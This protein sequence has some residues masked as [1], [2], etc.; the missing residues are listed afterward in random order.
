MPRIT[1]I[2][3]VR[4]LLDRDRSWAAYAIGD[5][6]PELA[7][8]CSWHAPADGSPALL[9]LYRGFDPPIVFAMGDPASLA[10]LFREIDA[11]AVSLHVRPDAIAAMRPIYRLTDIREVWR[12]V[13]PR[14]S[15]RPVSTAGV[16]ALDEFDR[17]AVTALIEDGRQHDEGPTF[18][19]PWMLRQGTFRGI[20][21]GA[22]LIAVAGTHLFSPDLGVCAVGKYTRGDRRRQGLAAC[23]TTAVVQQAISHEIATIL[24]NVGQGNA[25]ARRVY[26]RLGFHC[27]CAFVEG[28]ALRSGEV[29]MGPH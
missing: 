13:V 3:R 18:F 4:S 17:H 11:P 16:I 5:L 21:E 24:L 27:H 15:F 9:L 25:G 29:L 14:A 23:C 26:E 6:S 28:E 1:D 19:Q 2:S 12:M 20:R 10:P 22:E 7:A 8:H